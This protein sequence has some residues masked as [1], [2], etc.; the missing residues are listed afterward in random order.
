MSIFLYRRLADDFLILYNKGL[1][2]LLFNGM[3][4]GNNN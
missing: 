4:Y 2:S 1:E 3:H